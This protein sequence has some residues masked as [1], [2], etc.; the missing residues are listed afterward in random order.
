MTTPGPPAIPLVLRDLV[1]ALLRKQRIPVSAQALADALNRT[2]LP[3]VHKVLRQLEQQGLAVR[4]PG[5]PWVT[6][7]Q[8]R[9][10]RP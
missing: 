9:A 10:S 2:P 1:D 6:A 4:E 8:W 3:Q 5:Q 7:D